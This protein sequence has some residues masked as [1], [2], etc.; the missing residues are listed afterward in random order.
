MSEYHLEAAIAARHCAA[1]T[2]EETDW[3]EIQ[4]LYDVLMR[5][6]PSAVIAL[7]RAIAIRM[8]EGTARGV[9]ELEAVADQERLADY[10]FYHAA[11]GDMHVRM[12]NTQTS[13]A[14]FDKAVRLARNPAERRFFERRAR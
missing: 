10:P 11:L 4:A 9:Q 12:G 13:L 2:F 5:L 3:R 1:T 7:N 14:H 8:A 6:R